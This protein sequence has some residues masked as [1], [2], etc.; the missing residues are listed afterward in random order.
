MFPVILG[1]FPGLGLISLL[2]RQHSLFHREG[3]GGM[4]ELC[5]R[6]LISFQKKSV[7][8]VRNSE[9]GALAWAAGVCSQ[10]ATV[11]CS[12]AKLDAGLR[13]DA[14]GGSRVTVGMGSEWK[15]QP[16][17]HRPVSTVAGSSD[18]PWATVCTGP[19]ET[20]V[21]LLAVCTPARRENHHNSSGGYTRASLVPSVLTAG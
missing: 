16:W 5:F 4:A 15:D 1:C 18:P 3:P 13:A 10:S 6:A 20:Q 17:G 14:S 21:H 19:R 8:R 12:G 7:Q 11:S 2:I 9:Q